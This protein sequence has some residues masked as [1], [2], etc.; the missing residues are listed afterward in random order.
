MAEDQFV[1]D[2]DYTLSVIHSDKEILPG[3]YSNA[4][5]VRKFSLTRIFNFLS[6][7]VTT[8]THDSI[9]SPMYNSTGGDASAA[10]S[11]QTIIQNFSDIDSKE[12]IK[13][14]REKLVELGGH[15]PELSFD[16]GKRP[17]GLTHPKT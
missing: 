10:I 12:E 13:L 7:Q 3:N 6:Q 11:T 8:L 16:L 1:K 9:A 15:P 4:Q 2:N 5:Q 17:L 14:M